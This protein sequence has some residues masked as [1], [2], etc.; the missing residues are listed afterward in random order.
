MVHFSLCFDDEHGVPPPYLGRRRAMVVEAL[1]ILDFSSLSRLR[2]LEI[3]L[4]V[5]H[6]VTDGEAESWAGVLTEEIGIFD[7]DRETNLFVGLCKT[8]NACLEDDLSVS[9]QGVVVSE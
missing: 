9:C 8:F 1:P 3:F 2:L 4:H 5:K 7:A 6:A